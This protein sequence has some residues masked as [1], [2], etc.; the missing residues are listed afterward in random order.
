MLS[1]SLATRLM[2][3]KQLTI[4]HTEVPPAMQHQ[5]IGGRLV[6]MVLELARGGGATLRVVCPFAKSYLARHPELREL[7]SVVNGE[8]FVEGESLY[9][10]P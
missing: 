9:D 1:L 3:R 8:V 5:A 10:K 4:W 2:K 6:E 7:S